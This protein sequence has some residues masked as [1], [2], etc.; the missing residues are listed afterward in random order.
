MRDL[1]GTGGVYCPF[2]SSKIPAVPAFVLPRGCDFY[3]HRFY[4]GNPCVFPVTG[5]LGC[6]ATA[7]VAALAVRKPPVHASPFRPSRSVRPFSAALP[8][9]EDPDLLSVAP[10]GPQ[11]ASPTQRGREVEGL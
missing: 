1:S 8:T 6:R 11:T 5:C 2:A 10:L 9:N 7:L 3:A 4:I